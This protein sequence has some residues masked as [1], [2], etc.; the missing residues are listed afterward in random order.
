M[1]FREF[2][3]YE[4]WSKE[5]SRKILVRLRKVSVRAGI[6]LGVLAVVLGVALV[7]E[8]NWMTSGERKAATTALQEIDALQGYI[9]VNN[10]GFEEKDRQARQSLN[11]AEQ[12]ARTIRDNGAASDLSYYLFSTEEDRKT[13]ALRAEVRAEMQKRNILLQLHPA[14]SE[15]KDASET[16]LRLTFRSIVVKALR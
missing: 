16:Q 12:A 11:E 14:L 8:L 13:A 6:V 3:H 9:A 4:L 2:L 15:E 1:T 10:D 5:T 7:I